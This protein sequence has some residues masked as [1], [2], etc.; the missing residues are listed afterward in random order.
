M[1]EVG[2]GVLCP[3]RYAIMSTGENHHHVHE[4]TNNEIKKLL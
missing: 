1:H 3:V 4:M 2:R